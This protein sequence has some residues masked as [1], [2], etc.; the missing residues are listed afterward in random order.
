MP[1]WS[2][3]NNKN[4]RPKLNFQGILLFSDLVFG[5]TDSTPFPPFLIK[6][7]SRPSYGTLENEKAEY[8]LKTGD[9]A[10]VYYPT[11]GFT[12][13]AIE[14]EIA[15]VTTG[16]GKTLDSAAHFYNALTIMGKTWTYEK[17][18][19]IS[20][21]ASRQPSVVNN[22]TTYMRGYPSFITILELNDSGKAAG[23]WTIHKPLLSKMDFSGFSYEGGASINSISLSFEYKN[24]EFSHTWGE[25][26]LAAK[27]AAAKNATAYPY[28]STMGGTT[29]HSVQSG[30]DI[31]ISRKSISISDTF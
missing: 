1:S 4:L 13:N 2:F 26:D 24:F 11:Q 30:I 27:W 8:Q 12:T 22:I 7:F 31:D 19:M 25:K 10:Q 20:S 14:V 9:F 28:G 5:G 16:D 18:A 17:D 3:W 23:S 29:D 15:D 6:S 21:E